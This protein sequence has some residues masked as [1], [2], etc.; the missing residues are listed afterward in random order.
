MTRPSSLFAFYLFIIVFFLWIVI[1]HAQILPATPQTRTTPLTATAG[2]WE[3][4]TS[5][6]VIHHTASP[7]WTTAKD[8][9]KWHKERGWDGIG[10]HFV[11]RCDGKIEK[12]RSLSK[13]GAHAKGRNNRVGIALVG[14]DEFTDAQIVSLAKLLSDLGVSHIEGHHEE[15]PGKGIKLINEPDRVVLRRAVNH[16]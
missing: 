16:G 11:I 9:D 12:G 2:A 4:D 1:S 15:C 3:V 5:K 13:Q 8:I 6:A 10:Y 7:C 14:H